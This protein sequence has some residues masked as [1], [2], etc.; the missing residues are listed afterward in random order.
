MA[1]N[2]FLDLAQ[3]RRNGR[4]GVLA[5]V[6]RGQ[7]PTYRSPGASAVILDNDEVIGAVSGGCLQA[8]LLEAARQVAATG[9]ARLLT[10]HTG[11]PEDLLWGT[12]SGCGGTVQLLVAPVADDLLAE[13]AGRLKAGEA[14]VLETVIEP[15]P[16]L[17]LR[18]LGH[19]PAPAFDYRED[20][21][22]FCQTIEPPTP[23]L[24]CGA[25]DDARPV[26]AMAAAAGF[27]VM[28][29]DH[30]PAWATAQ[31]FPAADQVLI[32]DCGE[33]PTQ[34][35]LPAGSYVLLLTHHYERDLAH[36]GALLDQPV[37]YVGMLGSRDR[38]RQLVAQLLADRPDLAGATHL[39]LR[40]PVGLDLG[41]DGPQEIAVAVVAELLSHRAGRPGTPLTLAY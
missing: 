3:V 16:D 38:C 7:G 24:V 28:V 11:A 30:R 5:T 21:T 26:V 34:L 10:Y 9:A 31:R 20:G 6:V 36:L 4:H 1:D 27:R 39:K 25:G 15:G 18:R 13:V 22:V 40:A 41:A 37:A 14:V 19:G 17:G 2:A 35:P 29:A 32:C 8:D 33:L 12:G 23:L